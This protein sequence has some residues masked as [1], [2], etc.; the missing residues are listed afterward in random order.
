MDTGQQPGQA[1][2]RSPEVSTRP[3]V[4]VLVEDRV[5]S[6]VSLLLAAEIATVQ[7]ARLH[8]AHIAAP[9]VWQAGITG[10]PVPPYLWAEADRF[11]ADQ[12]REKVA[13]LLALTSVEWT[14]TWT[15]DGVHHTVM[16][17][18]RELS[19]VAV[20]MGAPRRRR[21]RVR[22]SVARW[23]VGQPNVPALV[24]SA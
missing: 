17:L 2:A 14:F 11:A 19:P 24:V 5:G 23:L 6:L 10:L 12:L 15:R 18:M 9:R 8:V 4:L 16:L 22:R 1:V 3:I 20:V 21:L 13:S 7:R